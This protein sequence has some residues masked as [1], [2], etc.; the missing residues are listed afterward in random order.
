MFFA[1]PLPHNFSVNFCELSLN[2]R[3]VL[4]LASLMKNQLQLKDYDS[5]D[6]KVQ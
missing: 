4:E 3:L 1:S 5:K 6:Y 2:T